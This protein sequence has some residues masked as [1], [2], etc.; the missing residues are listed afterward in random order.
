[1]P[2][3]VL[4]NHL[5]LIHDA[6]YQMG[7]HAIGDAAIVLVVNTNGCPRTQSTR[8]SSPLPES[9]LCGLQVDHGTDG[10][11]TFT[12]P[13]S[14]ILLILSKGATP[15]TSMAGDAAQQRLRGLM[16]HGITVAFPA[17]C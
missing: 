9:F 13:N 17:T 6:G 16:D 15:K 10:G 5:N 12:L 11:M 7:I 8:R 4:V 1:M 3:G 14:R 2:E